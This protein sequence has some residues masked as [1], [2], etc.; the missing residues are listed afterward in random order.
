M[1]MLVHWRED[2]NED[3]MINFHLCLKFSFKKTCVLYNFFLIKT[4]SVEDLTLQNG[5]NPFHGYPK[6][7]LF[8]FYLS[9]YMEQHETFYPP[10]FVQKKS[11][12]SNGR[13]VFIKA[14]RSSRVLQALL[15]MTWNT[16]RIWEEIM[17][18]ISTRRSSGKFM[19]RRKWTGRKMRQRVYGFRKERIKLGFYSEWGALGK[20]RNIR[21][22]M[23][24]NL[25]CCWVSTRLY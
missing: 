17:E 8:Y 4:L 21:R 10:K 14:A 18:V 12:Q 9:R 24:E 11:N 23:L 6:F 22:G 15:R 2:S 20:G 5:T 7:F 16:W 1:S 25:L 3:Y 13:I 19:M